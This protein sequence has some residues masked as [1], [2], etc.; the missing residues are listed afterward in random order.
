[1]KNIKPSFNEWLSFWAILISAVALIISA[2]Q[3]YM[4]RSH[5]ELSVVPLFDTEKQFVKKGTNDMIWIALKNDGLGPGIIESNTILHRNKAIDSKIFFVEFITKLMSFRNSSFALLQEGEV[6]KPGESKRIL[7]FDELN[8]MRVSGQKQRA[9][10]YKQFFS[11][12]IRVVYRSLY[13]RKYKFSKKL[14]KLFPELSR[15]LGWRS[16]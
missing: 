10:I 3:A 5:N 4:F 11:I 16:E 8:I 2:W 7:M 14:G 15:D 1:M 9:E 12:E 6:L 13:G